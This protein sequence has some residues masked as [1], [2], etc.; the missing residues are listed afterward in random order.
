MKTIEKDINNKNNLNYHNPKFSKFRAGES[1][2]PRDKKG[3]NPSPRVARRGKGGHGSVPELGRNPNLGGRASGEGADPIALRG[4]CRNGVTSPHISNSL[5]IKKEVLNELIEQNSF[6]VRWLQATYP[7][8]WAEIINH[9]TRKAVKKTAQEIFSD[10][11]RGLCVLQ[12][13]NGNLKPAVKREWID[14]RKQK[15]EVEE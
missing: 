10:I 9:I 15:W 11:E 8:R 2:G 5:K 12:D 13:E 6:V 3:E 1:F 7:S 4:G 14:G